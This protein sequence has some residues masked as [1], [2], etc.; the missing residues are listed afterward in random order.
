LG[1]TVRTVLGEYWGRRQRRRARQ[2]QVRRQLEQD[3]LQKLAARDPTALGTSRDYSDNDL[4]PW[5][6]EV[7]SGLVGVGILALIVFVGV[8]IAF[9]TWIK[10]LTGG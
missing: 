10:H 5:R 1:G 9:F 6:T 3:Y 4:T 2:Q 8:L 7:A